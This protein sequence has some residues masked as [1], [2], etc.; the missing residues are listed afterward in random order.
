MP[1][2]KRS[3]RPVV[4]IVDGDAE[5]RA[6][7]QRWFEAAGWSVR[8]ADRL[9]GFQPTP[10]VRPDYLVVAGPLDDDLGE[11]RPLDL[12]EREHIRSVLCA[13][14]GN[15]SGAARVLGVHRRT[16][17]RKLRATF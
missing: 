16:L 15:I 1:L 13:C 3:G 9:A 2:P 8:V 17:Q 12:V 10:S 4:L 6:P 11:I 14:G 7:I 5:R